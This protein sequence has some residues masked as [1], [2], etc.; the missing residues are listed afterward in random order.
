MTMKVK[1]EVWG[2]NFIRMGKNSGKDRIEILLKKRIPNIGY[3]AK[4]IRKML[5][6]WIVPDGAN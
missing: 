4:E 1:N 3:G 5:R 2:I 6:N